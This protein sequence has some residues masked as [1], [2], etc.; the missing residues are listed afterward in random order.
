[1]DNISDKFSLQVKLDL[2][3]L[4]DIDDDMDF[5]LKL[6]REES[7]VVLPGKNAIINSLYE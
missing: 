7:V 4:E 3:L 6:A 1:M 5:C 2:S